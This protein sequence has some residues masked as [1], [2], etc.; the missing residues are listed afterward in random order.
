MMLSYTLYFFLFLS[1]FPVITPAA[2]D[3]SPAYTA[4]EFILLNCGASSNLND[5]SKRRWDSDERTSYML[6]INTTISFAHRAS[7]MHPS[8]LQVP[9]ETVR[10]FPYTFGYSFPIHAGPKF[11]RLYFYPTAYSTFNASQSFFSV[12][13]NGFMFLRNFS[14]FLNTPSPSE[15]SFKKEFI[16]SVQENQSLTLTFITDTNSFA[17]INGIEIKV[18]NYVNC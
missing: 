15:P 6:P 14:P 7:D 17:F 2:A 10:I 16:I 11:I 8:V 18:F 3:A 12:T 9:Y 1:T 13:A 5:T 4:T